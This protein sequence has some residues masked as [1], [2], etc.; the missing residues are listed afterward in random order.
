MHIVVF[1]TTKNSAQAKK[2]SHELIKEKLIA[3]ANIVQGVQS[4]FWW[5][6][7]VD[8][9]QEVLLIVKTRQ[10][11]FPKLA[12]RVKALH[13]YQVPEIIALPILAGNPDYLKWIDESVEP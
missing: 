9:S 2:I 3:C 1:I 8:Q 11:L 6:K 5:K 12:K 7:K 10:N 4:V 13:S